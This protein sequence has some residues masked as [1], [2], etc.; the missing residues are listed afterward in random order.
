ML[1]RHPE[2]HES[3]GL[4]LEPLTVR[5]EISFARHADAWPSAGFPVHVQ[6]VDQGGHAV[7]D[8]FVA[9]CRVTV[10]LRELQPS[11]TRADATLHARLQ[12]PS[13]TAG[14]WIV[15]VEVRDERGEL[16]GMD[17]AEVGYEVGEA[18][19][20]RKRGRSATR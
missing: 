17:F 2:T 18:G 13:G 10:N 1:L 4:R 20:A 9:E 7:P 6:L 5:A 19:S 8:S 11:W 12:R 3:V 16:L 15:R 14:P